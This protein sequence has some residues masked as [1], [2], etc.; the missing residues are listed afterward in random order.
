MSRWSS[1]QQMVFDTVGPG[2]LH[3]NLS[4]ISLFHLYTL[5]T[6][7]FGGGAIVAKVLQSPQDY[8]PHLTYR[9]L[10]SPNMHVILLLLRHLVA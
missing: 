9:S 3:P 8:M 2:W 10:P 6:H 7:L 4:I 1:L 5:W